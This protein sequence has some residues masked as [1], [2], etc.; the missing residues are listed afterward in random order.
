MLSLII[1]FTRTMEH[2][3]LWQV[4]VLT[5]GALVWRR[6]VGQGPL[7]WVTQ[8]VA[9]T[10]ARLVVGTP[11]STLPPDQPAALPPLALEARGPRRDG[12]ARRGWSHRGHDPGS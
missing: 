10:V 9:R 5:T 6:L 12:P 3:Y 1:F 7:E 11:T 8:R 4:L 2:A